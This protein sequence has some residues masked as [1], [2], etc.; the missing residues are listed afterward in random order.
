MAMETAKTIP[1]Y[2]GGRL[3]A[4]REARH[5]RQDEVASCA[6]RWGLDWTPTTVATLETGR[7]A[8]KVE[9]FFLLP[10]IAAHQNPEAVL[11][12]TDTPLEW[13]E[14]LKGGP[15]YLVV[16]SPMVLMHVGVLREALS[17]K[18]TT[19]DRTQ[20]VSLLGRQ[21]QMSEAMRVWYPGM[22]SVH[23]LAAV[24]DQRAGAERKAARRL[25]TDPL[26]VAVLAWKLWGRSF[27]EERDRRVAD[28]VAAGAGPERLQALRGHV[29]RALIEELREAGVEGWQPKRQASPA[30][31]QARPKKKRR[32][33]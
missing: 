30:R 25:R 7:R 28:Q 21:L 33:P 3:R 17:G 5:L 4:C 8:L 20:G 29:A 15:D 14:F 13:A 31:T 12:G 6:R 32:K 24:A 19:L 16:L 22:P 26:A 1:Q 23:G 11:E 18:L 9:E 10:W 27:T 2:L